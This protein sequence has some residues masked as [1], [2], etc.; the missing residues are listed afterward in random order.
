MDGAR[1]GR[2]LLTYA[3]P[4]DLVSTMQLGDLVWV[5]VRKRWALAVAV[6]L[7]DD[8]PDFATRPIEAMV[9]PPLRL[10]PDRIET[11]RWLARE[12]ASSLFA[13]CAPFLPPGLAG[14]ARETIRLADPL[15]TP[16]SLTVAQRRL[17]DFLRG[18]GETDLEAARAALG[19]SLASVVPKLESLGMIERSVS[20]GW[21]PPAPKPQRFVRLLTPIEVERAP[22]QKAVV[23]DLVR[24]SRLARSGEPPLVPLT[25]LLARTGTDHAVVGALARKGVVEEVTLARPIAVVS[26]PSEAVP[27]LTPAQAA[28]WNAI[29]ASLVGRDPTPFLLHGVTGSGK[30]EVYLRS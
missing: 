2:D 4:P 19:S 28:A 12:T 30:T 20:G 29:E 1:S 16:S 6:R 5:G 11:A 3:V 14:S 7:H 27:T 8:E 23:D 22:R 18:R 10:A 21:K 15:P 17:V 13:A 25:D 9:E 24:R 26:E